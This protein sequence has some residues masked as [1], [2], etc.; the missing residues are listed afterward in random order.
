MDHSS[1]FQRLDVGGCRGR[2][3]TWRATVGA[4]CLSDSLKLRRQGCMSTLRTPNSGTLLT[5]IKACLQNGDRFLEETYDL[6][7]RDPPSSRYFIV[8]IA[9]EEFAKAFIIYLIREGAMPFTTTVLRAINDHVCKQL[10]GLIMD[11]MIMHWDEP[12][13]LRALLEKDFAAGEGLPNDVGSAIDILRYERIGRWE[14]D[15]WVWAEDPEYDPSALA[16]A[17]GKRDRRKQDSIYVRIG[18]DG[19]VASMPTTITEQETADELER[20]RRYKRFVSSLLEEN[21]RSE[22]FRKTTAAIRR[23]FASGRT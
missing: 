1:D 6:E 5:T 10:V 23:V 20:A 3:V 21:D 11:Y 13:E 18:R 4:T 7:F 12:E 9:Q 15:S 8:M 2:T 17:K 16:V 14:S 19:S 22:R